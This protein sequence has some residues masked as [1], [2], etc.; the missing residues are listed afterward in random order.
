MVW[1]LGYVGCEVVKEVKKSGILC[2]L[3]C[4]LVMVVGKVQGGLAQYVWCNSI[5]RLSG[6]GGWNRSEKSGIL[7]GFQQLWV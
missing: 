6:C 7:L 4:L 2:C 5:R 1:L 3:R